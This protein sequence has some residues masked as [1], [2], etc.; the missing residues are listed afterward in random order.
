MRPQI[1][2]DVRKQAD[3]PVELL[4]RMVGAGYHWFEGVLSPSVPNGQHKHVLK[5]PWEDEGTAGP[6]ATED[7]EYTINRRSLSVLESCKD[8]F[9]ACF[10]SGEDSHPPQPISTLLT[11]FP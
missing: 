2:S 10:A 7:A 5:R 1:Q 11:P 3:V 9:F 8:I 4:G 6:S